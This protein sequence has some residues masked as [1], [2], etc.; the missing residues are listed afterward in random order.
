M[1]LD[2]D[3]V[4]AANGKISPIAVKRKA[5]GSALPNALA[6]SDGSPS[7]DGHA[8]D[9]DYDSE[10]C[11]ICLSAVENRVRRFMRSNVARADCHRVRRLSRSLVG[12][13]TSAIKSVILSLQHYG[14]D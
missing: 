5:S 11:A 2:D 13:A 4:H 6:E 3:P 12:T 10:Q 8:E 14:S 9:D 1:S 7:A